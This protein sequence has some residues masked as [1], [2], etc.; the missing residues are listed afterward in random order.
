MQQ[1][2]QVPPMVIT[3][4]TISVDTT[5]KT[6]TVSASIVV[7][8]TFM[9]LGGIPTSTYNA[10]S[11]VP[12]TNPNLAEVAI[13]Y[14]VSVRFKGSSFHANI[15][16]ALI[17][18]VNSL[19][20]N[21]MVSITP[22]AVEFLLDA[23]TSVS[24]NLFSHLSP[25]A[26][27]ELATPAY[28]PLGPSLAW[29]PANYNSVSNTYYVSNTFADLTSYPSPALCPGGYQSCSPR[30]WPLKCLPSTVNVSC[31]QL[32]SYISNTA[33]PVLPLTANKTLVVNYLNGL[34]AFATG[35]DGFFPSLL[36]W[37]WR[38]ID[39][40]WNDFWKVNADPLTTTRSIGTYPK[41]YGGMQKS[42]ILIFNNTQ[43]WNDFVPDADAYYINKCGDATAVVGG[44][45]HWWMTG[46]GMVP[47]PTDL[48]SNVDDITCENRW[49][50]TMDKGLGLNLSDATNYRGTVDKATFQQRILAEVGA[51][52]FRICNNIKANNIDVYLLSANNTATLAPCCNV[53]ANAVTIANS[54]AS[55]TAGLNAVKTKILAKIQ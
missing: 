14:E 17:N 43:Y 19:P 45:N 13:V 48:L 31:S 41:P 4:P 9:A 38:T 46:Y 26:N 34:K 22:I 54:S 35:V 49:Y 44:V 10:T 36:S 39:P 42:M 8:N 47:V 23:N 51:K 25:T 32:Y 33:Y 28:F 40:S 30:M 37:G 16:N 1:Q 2:E 5:N 27:D 29:T 7:A 3:G 21:V 20:N 55:I 6:V 52:F 50:K 11:T 15:C 12:L 18:F 53:G 24:A